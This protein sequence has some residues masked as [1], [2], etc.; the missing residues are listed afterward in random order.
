M[1]RPPFDDPRQGA[2]ATVG[3]R[4]TLASEEDASQKLREPESVE[5]SESSARFPGSFGA[6]LPAA[7]PSSH[8]AGAPQA[9]AT[10]TVAPAASAMPAEPE[11]LNL[12]G[13]PF[14]NTRPVE[15][16]AV[17]LWVLG[18]LLL[19][20]NVALFRGYLTKSQTTRVKLAGS[21]RDIAREKRAGAELQD[22]LGTLKLEQQ[23]REVTFLNRKIDERTFSW[24]LLFERMAEVLP[25]Q[26]RLLRLKPTN[27]VQRDIGLGPRPSAHELNPPPVTLTMHCEAKND[28]ALLRFVDNMFAHPAFAE[29][30]LQSEERL[31]SGLVRFDLVVQYQPNAP[32]AP[33]ARSPAPPAR[34]PGQAIPAGRT[35]RVPAPAA[36]PSGAATGSGA[37]SVPPAA[38]APSEHSVAGGGMESPARP[39]SP[40][41]AGLIRVTPAPPHHRPPAARRPPPLPPGTPGG[42]R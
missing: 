20:A 30:N 14:V 17:I 36:T 23:N 40:A 21:E 25:D 13:R 15:R 5:S 42:R 28:E 26:V 39:V 3:P 32:H 18:A 27:V 9:P 11:S 10:A 8:A 2:A 7:A 29:P 31:D 1:T 34:R 6:R 38:A 19:A 24:S 41:G 12:A 37:L 33:T 4:G 22:R 16:V 35:R